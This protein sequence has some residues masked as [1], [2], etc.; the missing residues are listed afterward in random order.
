MLV[1]FIQVEDVRDLD[2]FIK[3]VETKREVGCL[4]RYYQ[5]HLRRLEKCTDGESFEEE[6]KVRY[7]IRIYPESCM[8]EWIEYNSYPVYVTARA[9][10]NQQ[11]ITEVLLSLL[12]LKVPFT[13]KVLR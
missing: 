6:A 11:Q 7:E 13:C 12:L 5:K 2:I 10:Y 8:F 1:V 4:K 9:G 3:N